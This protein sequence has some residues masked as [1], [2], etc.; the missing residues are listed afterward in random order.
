MIYREIGLADWYR[1]EDDWNLQEVEGETSP[2]D[3]R[4]FWQRHCEASVRGHFS[5]VTLLR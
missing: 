1:A 4:G 3:L 5:S 2:L